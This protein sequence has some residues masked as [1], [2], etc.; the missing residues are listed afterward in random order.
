MEAFALGGDSGLPPPPV[1]SPSP[2]DNRLYLRSFHGHVT[3]NLLDS[4]LKLFKAFSGCG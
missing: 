4:F 3:I 2:F 1:S